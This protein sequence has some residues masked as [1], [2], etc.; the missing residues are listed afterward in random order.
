MAPL[1][2]DKQTVQRTDKNVIFFSEVAENSNNAESGSNTKW[3]IISRSDSP[4]N[5]TNT[6]KGTRFKLGA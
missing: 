6:Q 1:Q 4:R 2:T 5:S 3:R